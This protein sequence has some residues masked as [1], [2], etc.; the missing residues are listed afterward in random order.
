VVHDATLTCMLTHTQVLSKAEKMR[1]RK[2]EK[3]AAK[4]LK[5]QQQ[6]SFAA[7]PSQPPSVPPVHPPTTPADPVST[8]HGALMPNQSVSPPAFTP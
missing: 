8:P 5:A 7:A 1:K 4:A 3:V 2:Q 6:P